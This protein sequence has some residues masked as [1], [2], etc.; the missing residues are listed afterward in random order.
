MSPWM[1]LFL[2]PPRGPFLRGG[3]LFIGLALAA[4]VPPQG[5]RAEEAEGPAKARGVL[6]RFEGPITPLLEQY[7]YRKL[8]TA[9]QQRADVVIVEID[10]PG[11]FADSSFRMAER[12]RDL[13]WARTVAYIPRQALSGAAIAAL[14]CDEIVMAR[15]ARLGDAGAIS[16]G[17]D[18]MFRY[19][20]EKYRS[21]LAARIRTLASAK[22][23]PPAL[24]EAMVDMDLVVY[25]VENAKTGEQTFMSENEIKASADPAAWVKKREVL[26]SGKKRFLTVNGEQAV[27]LQLAQAL[28]QDR[29]ELA[30]RYRLAEDLLVLAPTS[31]DTAVAI[32]NLPLVTGLLFVVGLVALYVEFSAPGIGLGGLIAGLCFAIFFW[33]R[34]LGGTAGWLEVILFLA[35]GVFLAVELFVLPGFGV[36]G[37]AGLSLILVSV[38]MASQHFLIPAT[39]RQL[40]TSLNSLLVTAASGFVF[41]IVAVALSHYFN[42]LPVVRWLVLESPPPAGAAPE[43]EQGVAAPA[44]PPHRFPVRTG[45]QGTAVSPLRPAG[46]ARFAEHYLDVVADGSFVDK[47]RAVRIVEISGN[48]VVVREVEEPA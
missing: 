19:V 46:K 47:G 43:G 10:S 20:P 21:D 9:H 36:A 16:Q 48:R 22:G 11:G 6:I 18:A 26:E 37:L 4:G 14:G 1:C 24:A 7:L 8:E 27:A 39:P 3:A 30:A 31:V 28:A 42:M 13:G 34:F 15:H 25:C 45:D 33:S 38:L 23:R 12:L 44:A 41:L 17:E 2:R 32:L 5:P 29:R 35:G 40:A